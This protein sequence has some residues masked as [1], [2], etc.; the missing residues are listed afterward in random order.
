M[1]ELRHLL[2]PLRVLD[3]ISRAGGVVRA[4]DQLHVTPGAVSQQLKQLETAL[5]VPLFVKSGRHLIPNEAGKELADGLADLFDRM[6]M[7]VADTIDRG[8]NPRLRVKVSP[9]FAVK[10]LVPKLAGFYAAH[11]HIDLDITTSSR[12]EDVHLGSADFALRY[13]KGGWEDV[14]SELLFK[15]SL[16]PMCSPALAASI[17]EPRDLLNVKLLHSMRRPG[18]WSIWF[19]SAGL[20]F[21][22]SARRMELANLTLCM[23][24]ASDG[25]GVAIGP[26]AYLS[27]DR[28][29]D[30]I[31]MPLAHVADTGDATYLICDPRK[32]ETPTFR[33]FRCWMQSASEP[34]RSA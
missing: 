15:D 9:D 14:H 11:P 4:A 26:A 6:E 5:G 10:W 32:A 31:V 2:G 3:T 21:D 20:E 18:A 13:G 29:S 28:S 23:Q 27:A 19:A 16:V 25:L 1:P 34:D 24:A 7:L 30:R 22:A 12:M 17:R 8:R 33:E